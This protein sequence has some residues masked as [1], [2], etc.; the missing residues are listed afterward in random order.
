[1]QK[2][3]KKLSSK[4]GKLSGNLVNKQAKA[5][6][7]VTTANKEY[8]SNGVSISPAIPSAG[9]N[10]KINYDGLLSKNGANHIYAHIGFGEKW[11]SLS[12]VKMTK[13]PM[14][15]EATISVLPSDTLNVC[16]KD[17]A[18]NWDNNSGTNYTFDIMK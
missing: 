4:E 14:G 5:S 6:A 3:E 9:D 12:D 8:V 10:I 7:Q 18:S 1:M 15:F 16:F 11:S 17:C 2:T 13:T